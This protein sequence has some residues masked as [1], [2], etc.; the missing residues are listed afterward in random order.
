MHVLMVSKNRMSK[1]A[2][3]VYC[4]YPLSLVF[5]HKLCC[6]IACL[7]LSTGDCNSIFIWGLFWKFCGIENSVIF[8]LFA[9]SERIWKLCETRNRYISSWM[10]FVVVQRCKVV[11]TCPSKDTFKFWCGRKQMLII[12]AWK[13]IIFWLYNTQ[14]SHWLWFLTR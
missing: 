3:C 10:Q 9:S 13:A 1:I 2:S 8:I 5:I 12:W 4:C 7:V 11:N 6:Y 14:Y